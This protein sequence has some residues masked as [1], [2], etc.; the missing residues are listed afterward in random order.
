MNSPAA[1]EILFFKVFL[2]CNDDEKLVVDDYL[3]F[4]DDRNERKDS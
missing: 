1:I 4:L 2:G 3:S